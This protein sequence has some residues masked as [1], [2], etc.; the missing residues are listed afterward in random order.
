MT[1]G[2]IFYRCSTTL[3][4]KT[5]IYNGEGERK[6]KHVERIFIVAI[7]SRHIIFVKRNVKRK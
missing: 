7:E 5:A 1:R 3:S 4:N 6:K 2:N